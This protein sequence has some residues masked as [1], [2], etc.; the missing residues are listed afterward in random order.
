MGNTARGSPLYLSQKEN[1]P[2][3]AT[4]LLLSALIKAYP[5]QTL[6]LKKLYE[7]KNLK[8]NKHPEEHLGPL[9]YP[10]KSFAALQNLVRL[11]L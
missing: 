10:S 7:K 11:S 3:P 9:F 8:I 4:K 1:G 6:N 2:K 5:A